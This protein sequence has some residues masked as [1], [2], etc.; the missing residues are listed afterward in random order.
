MM[1]RLKMIR[2]SILKGRMRYMNKE[3]GLD[4]GEMIR[5]EDKRD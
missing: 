5:I 4:I 2:N 1:L 3:L